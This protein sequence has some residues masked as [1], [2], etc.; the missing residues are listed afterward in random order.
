M[1]K[2][3]MEDRCQPTGPPCLLADPKGKAH[4]RE[5][6]TVLD[7]VATSMTRY[8]KRVAELDNHAH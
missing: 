2:E 5:W 8:L 3:G 7:K 6:A 1:R 4:L